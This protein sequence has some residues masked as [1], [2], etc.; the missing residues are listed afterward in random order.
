M[1]RLDC[2]DEDSG[3]W[4]AITDA[5]GFQS[6]RRDCADAA[7]LP[8]DGSFNPLPTADGAMCTGPKDDLS[9]LLP[10][11]WFTRDVVCKGAFPS[12]AAA[13]NWLLGWTWL[14]AHGMLHRP[15]SCAPPPAPTPSA[16]LSCPG[17]WDAGRAFPGL[18]YAKCYK[19]LPT[20][21]T[22]AGCSTDCERAGGAQLCI[23]SLEESSF[24]YNLARP[25]FATCGYTSQVG[26]VWLGLYQT[27]TTGASA[28][29]WD[30]WRSGCSS[31]YRDWSPGEPN[32]SGG[33][34]EDCALLGFAGSTQ[35]FDAPCSTRSACVCERSAGLDEPPP[36]SPTAHP[37][38]P[39]SPPSNC[40]AGWHDGGSSGRCY[41]ALPGTFTAAACGA[42]CEVEGAEQLCLRSSAENAAVYD[43]FRPA[44]ATCGH[45]SQAGCLWL[46]LYQVEASF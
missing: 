39:P 13:D 17:G 6:V 18:T 12:A 44:E 1:F 4:T 30:A 38:P 21:N 28:D 3:A 32:D 41:R 10:A 42:Q 16:P 7:C 36:P 20:P 15:P 2:G 19:V 37:P 8:R 25:T 29:H 27:T 34:S 9:A 43:L 46:G 5:P 24:I 26:C 31:A 33:T 14:D 22:A 11:G 40:P 45:T 35:W 23:G